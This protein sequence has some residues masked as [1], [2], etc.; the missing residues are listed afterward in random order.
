MADYSLR[1]RWGDDLLDR[2]IACF[3]VLLFEVYHLLGISEEELVFIQQAFCYKWDDRNPYPS[4]STIAAKM[5]K[6]K[7]TIQH[8]AESLEKK[9]LM[10]RK[11]RL[12]GSSELDFSLLLAAMR[13]LLQE[14]KDSSPLETPATPGVKNLSPPPAKNPSPRTRTT[15]AEKT[16]NKKE[17][18]L[19]PPPATPQAPQQVNA[20]Q[21]SSNQEARFLGKLKNA[22]EIEGIRLIQEHWR[23]SIAESDL[24]ARTAAYWLFAYPKGCWNHLEKHGKDKAVQLIK[25]AM[26]KASEKHRQDKVRN[27][28]RYLNA[29][30][31]AE[32]PYLMP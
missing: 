22:D 27:L 6:T 26:D 3:P 9:K 30:I 16:E 19:Q 25:Q 2:G 5:G 23:M 20:Q 15:K 12:G 14:M 7:R 11:P 31:Q 4:F 1:A 32:N 10:E 28:I 18:V 21:L 24:P 17:P 8:Y 29:G 13:G